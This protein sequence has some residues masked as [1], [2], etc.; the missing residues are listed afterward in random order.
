[1]KNEDFTDVIPTRGKH[2]RRATFR[3]VKGTAHLKNEGIVLRGVNG[4]TAA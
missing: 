4:T 3:G 2:A 1:M